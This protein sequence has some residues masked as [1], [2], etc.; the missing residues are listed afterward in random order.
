M[1]MLLAEFELL[2]LL[3]VLHRGDTAYAVSVHDELV[4]RSRRRVSTGAVYVTL[5][6]LERKGLLRSR[7]GDSTPERGGRAKRFYTLS[8][9]GLAALRAERAVMRRMWDGLE[10]LVDKS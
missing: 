2:V 8:A 9:Q 3:A 1:P 6:R 10:P 4:R 7:L 5:D